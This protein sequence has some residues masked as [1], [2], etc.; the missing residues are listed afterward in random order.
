VRERE[1]ERTLA[2][3]MQ[4]STT[5]G[6][7]WLPRLAATSDSCSGSRWSTSLQS[8]QNCTE[9]RRRN[10]TDGKGSMSYLSVHKKYIYLARYIFIWLRLLI[11]LSHLTRGVRLDKDYFYSTNG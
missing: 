3:R 5:N 11:I 1:R 7:R 2:K 9:E 6:S 8:F 4:C 10:M